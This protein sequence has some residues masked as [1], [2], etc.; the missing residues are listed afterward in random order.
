MSKPTL[1]NASTL[2]LAPEWFRFLAGLL[3]YAAELEARIAA[4]EAR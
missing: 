4:L 3:A 1:P 2:A